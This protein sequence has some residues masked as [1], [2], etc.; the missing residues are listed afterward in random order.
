MFKAAEHFVVKKVLP[1]QVAIIMVVVVFIQVVVLLCWQL[2]D[3]LRWEREVIAQDIFGYPTKS[4]GSCRSDDVL[5][6]LITLAV[7]DGSMLLYAL[8]LCFVTQNVSSDYQEV[9]DNTRTGR[10]RYCFEH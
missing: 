3:P 5:R 7:I 6:F 2:I 8:Y 1:Q 10:I 4:V 9:S